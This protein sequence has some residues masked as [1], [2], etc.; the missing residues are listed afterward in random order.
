MSRRPPSKPS[1]RR[2]TPRVRA[3]KPAGGA[4][5]NGASDQ[6]TLTLGQIEPIEIQQE[7]ERSFLE[8]SMSVITQRAL[9]DARDGLA[10]VHRRILHTMLEDGLRP[11]RAH[12]KSAEV[13][14]HVIARYH[15]H[16]LEAVYDAL[17]R[18][19]QDFSLRYKLVDGHGNFGSPDDPPAAYRYCST[20]DALVRLADGS[21]RRI[22]EIVPGAEPNSDTPIDIKLLDRFGNP[23]VATVFF[24]SGEHPTKRLVTRA[25]YEL[26][27]TG[28]HPVLCLEEIAGVP[29][30]QWRTLEEI[31]PGTVVCIS[32]AFRPETEGELTAHE[33]RLGILAGMFVAEGW[34]SEKKA[35]FDNTDH[36]Y[37]MAAVYAYEQLVGGQF[38]LKAP[39]IESGSVLSGLSINNLNAL[40]RSPLT[41][42]IGVKSARKR[43]PKFVWESRLGAKR[44]FLAALFEGDGTVCLAQR[45]SIHIR[46][47]TYSEGLARDVQKLLLEF[48]IASRVFRLKGG[49]AWRVSI[50][51]R[52]DARL[53]AER[54]NFLTKKRD[55]LAKALEQ[56]PLESRAMSADHIPFMSAYVRSEAGRG[57]R[58]WL[59]KRN[60]DRWERLEQLGDDFWPL[61]ANTEAEAVIRPLVESGYFYDTVKTVE[62]AGV[63]P[64]YSVR[65]DSD[66]HSFLANG[67][68]N[69]NTECRLGPLALEL[70]AGIDEGTVDFI[71]NYS[72]NRKQPSVL[73]ARFPNLLVN[74]REG[75]A[76]GMA[77]KIPTHNLGEVIDAAIHVLDHPNAT[78]KDL[79]KFVKAPDFPTGGIILGRTGIQD[80][81][82]T[83]RGSIKIRAK[84]EIDEGKRGP[85][86]VVTEIPY[87]T[88][89]GS[90]GGRIADLVNSKQLDGIRNVV[91][92][93]AQGR[94]RLVIELKKDANAN[95]VLNNL[96][97]HTP[98]QTSFPMNM[99]ALVDG[100]PRTLN[101]AQAISAYVDHQVEVV[102]R[103]TRFRLRKA[104]DRAHIIEGL[105]KALDKI[106]VII[107]LIRGS[108]DRDD[109]RKK[110]MAAPHKFS[111]IQANHILDMPLVRLTRLSRKE[112]GDE[113]NQLKATIKE[114]KSILA[115][116]AKLRGVIKGELTAIK[117]K[118]GDERRTAL[119]ADVG[120]MELTDLIVDEDIV[121]VRTEAG[122]IKTVQ[123]AKYRTQHRGGRGVQGANLKEADLV[124]EIVHT[125]THAQLLLF[126]N[127][128]RVF[129]LR[130][131]ELPM[132]ERTARGTALI[133]L[134]PLRKEES[135]QAIISSREVDS[136]G[137]L[138]FATKLGQVKKTPFREY[139]KSRKEGFI[140]INLRKRD[141]LVRVVATSGSDDIIIVTRQGQSIRFTEAVVRSMGR[142]AAGV[143]G[144]RLRP[145]D[146]VVSCD[147]VDDAGSIL[148]VTDAGFGKRTLLRHWR[149]I[150]RGNQGIRAIK[151]TER[152]GYVVGA[153]L[154]EPEDEVFM[155]SSGGITVR[156]PVKGISEQ[157]R[158]ATG[159]RV[160]ALERGQRVASAAPAFSTRTD[161]PAQ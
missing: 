121:V 113:M 79:M 101:L 155:V 60:F 120:E 65:V 41:E 104:E 9:P 141:E 73:P 87:Q 61:I 86:I 31:K 7:M 126:S 78:P 111:E 110:L 159:V 54:V 85:E 98:L 77:T 48:G 10:P 148:I 33:A 94:T 145:G 107:R 125:T 30:L 32:R 105:I 127:Q 62:D 26:S 157:G 43:I 137:Y 51:N 151:L 154:V 156:I 80:A 72:G 135:I 91:D 5:G 47:D 144:I 19:G 142:S 27:G 17:V 132:K 115:S 50:T 128:G 160:M 20:G 21:T 83:G 92:Q 147:V 143:R 40:R 103:R 123:A 97:K 6:P 158:D 34:I 55:K 16:S 76:V 102:Q 70:L 82:T 24:H 100:V 36:E 108:A 119:A 89:P 74:G 117:D 138:F 4:G 23:T 152:K 45:L 58:E 112:L 93:S 146:E 130:A 124:R 69:H 11:D 12:V 118:Y 57:R 38:C 2:A 59:S 1:R 42:L 53:F 114:L 37:F 13:V 75:I 88:S 14:G 67:F 90:I 106:D 29:M 149:R 52:R 71:D 136:D 35:G 99:V 18:M 28:N 68:V 15:P 56:I 116:D 22:D 39:V 25:G 139:D 153:F 3:R 66:D 109:A 122:Y 46:Y 81:Y 64:V 140:A 150:G 49:I 133:N 8:Y 131:H 161:E 84:A 95:V 63:Q 96:W 129:R 134:L 44:A